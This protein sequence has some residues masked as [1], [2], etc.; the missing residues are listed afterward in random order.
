ME[1]L[2]ALIGQT[3]DQYRI[4]EQIG[5]GGM[6]TVFKAYQPGLNRDVALK[7]LPPNFAKRA[8]FT[9]RFVREAHAIGNL[10]H[11]NILPVYDSGQDK[12]YSY[13]A[14]RY[15]PNATTLAHEMK[16][17]MKTERIIEVITQIAGALDHAHKAGIIHRDVKPSNV[18]L[19]GQWGLLSDFGLAKMVENSVDLTGTG[20]GMGTPAYMSPEQGMGKKVDHRTDIYA[21]GIILYEMLTGQVPHRAETPIATVMKRINE[22]LP[23]PRSLNP[24]IPEAVERVLLKA[25]AVEP[26]DR[27]D[28]AGEMAAVLKAAFGPNPDEVLVEVS[29]A[30]V[31]PP[32]KTA[33]PPAERTRIAVPAATP[34]ER[35]KSG[36]PIN[37]LGFG[38]IGV[39][40]F[41]VLIGIGVLIFLQLR[42]P[43]VQSEAAQNTPG[44][45][46]PA[47]AIAAEPT[48][49][50]AP[51]EAPTNIPTTESTTAPPA[52]SDSISM[53]VPEVTPPQVTAL[54][55]TPPQINTPE[56]ASAQ[57]ATS[58]TGQEIAD[59]ALAE[60]QK[61][62]PDAVLSEISTSGLGPLDAEGK[63]TDWILKFWSPSSKGLNTLMFIK[64]TFNSSPTDLPTPK[65]TVL[66]GVILDTKRLYDI[67]EK[68]GAAKYTAE[69][70]RPMA[71]ITP[72]P[73]DETQLTWYLNYA[74]GDFRVVYTVI[75]DAKTGEVIQAIPL[76]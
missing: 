68:A 4:I 67:A 51:T 12:G 37:A 39:L 53:T 55:V 48:S 14:M 58:L 16:L 44:V 21:L 42:S 61:W 5:E 13:I 11:P 28:S 66:D 40:I 10:H 70:Y 47:Q 24:N 8:D 34:A 60:A 6:A 71:A 31:T 64:G 63:S 22:P 9:E 3:L 33:S 43:S 46:T 26:A 19:D 2:Q 35:G 18:L 62:Q 41:L 36:L 76:E 20:V 49:T 29:Q 74:G 38:A 23:L 52:E 54:E 30:Y 75:I 73:L 1:N 32:S 72:Y 7:V 27:F 45:E 57:A 56:V 15:I 25:L 69:G 50:P 17:P 65:T 59:L